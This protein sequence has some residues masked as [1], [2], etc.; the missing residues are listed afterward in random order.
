MGRALR[1]I[2]PDD[3]S[4][5]RI[6]GRSLLESAISMTLFSNVSTDAGRPENLGVAYV[7][8]MPEDVR[9]LAELVSKEVLGLPDSPIIIQQIRR[10]EILSP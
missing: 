1:S 2:D 6:R 8:L 5:L 10:G 4:M 7:F 9:A 3:V